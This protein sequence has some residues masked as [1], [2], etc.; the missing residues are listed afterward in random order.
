PPPRP[1]KEDKQAAGPVA[2]T[3]VVVDAADAEERSD[4][5]RA[6]EE[7]RAALRAEPR[8]PDADRA[9]PRVNP[10]ALLVLFRATA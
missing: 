1:A 7:I 8:L 6:A 3:A 5:Q 4:V 2:A 9:D 10:D